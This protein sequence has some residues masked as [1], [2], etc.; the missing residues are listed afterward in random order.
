LEEPSAELPSLFENDGYFI[1]CK[2]IPLIAG[3]YDI[4]GKNRDN[5]VLALSRHDRGPGQV[6]T[7]YNLGL[8]S[9]IRC[10]MKA[11]RI[12][13]VSCPLE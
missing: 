11:W 2:T 6:A 10:E 1:D 8:T 12:T 9:W 13:G 7:A 3:A 4:D 5:P